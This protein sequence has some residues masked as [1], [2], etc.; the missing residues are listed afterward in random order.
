[1]DE[2]C[3]ICGNHPLECSCANLC[4]ILDPESLTELIISQL[5]PIYRQFGG[6]PECW[7]KAINYFKEKES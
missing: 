3:K 6:R 7:E 4:T 5:T 2:E 1:M